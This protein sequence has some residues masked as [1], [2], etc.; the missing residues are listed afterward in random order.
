MHKPTIVILIKVKLAAMNF[1][2]KLLR[3]SIKAQPQ[4]Y[5]VKMNLE[6]ILLCRFIDI[7]LIIIFWYVKCIKFVN[8]NIINNL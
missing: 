8:I 5:S 7:K 6:S 3:Y 4:F 2:P 1:L